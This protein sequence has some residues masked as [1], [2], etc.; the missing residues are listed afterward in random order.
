MQKIPEIPEEQRTSIINK[1]IEII[2]LQQDLIQQLT[3][4]IENKKMQRS[5]VP[6]ITSKEEEILPPHKIP[7]GHMNF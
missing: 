1:L 5:E 7:K 3:K 4:E 2:H 6:T